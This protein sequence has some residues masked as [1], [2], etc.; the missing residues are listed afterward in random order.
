[1]A[2]SWDPNWNN[3]GNNNGASQAQIAAILGT[4]MNQGASGDNGLRMT[5]ASGGTGP[6]GDNV[7]IDKGIH[8]PGPHIRVGYYGGTWHIGLVTTG[9]G[10]AEFTVG[11]VT[12]WRG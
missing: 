1:M 10:V 2:Y 7:I 12:Q 4:A 9:P 8:P 6:N 3:A 5:L 11:A